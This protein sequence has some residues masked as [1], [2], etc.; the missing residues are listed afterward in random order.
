MNKIFSNKFVKKNRKTSNKKVEGMA[1]FLEFFMSSHVLIYKTS[2]DY[3][4]GI[5]DKKRKYIVYIQWINLW[6]TF[7]R[8][9]FSVL[10]NNETVDSFLA[11]FFVLLNK[12][13]LMV[14]CLILI[15]LM[16]GF[17]GK[18]K[19][20][21]FSKRINLFKTIFENRYTFII[22]SLSSESYIPLSVP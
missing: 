9:Q 11:N 2:Y 21:F 19:K 18:I 14:E 16:S 15:V 3:F 22:H 7:L 1:I 4:D 17:I 8:F 20:P 5:I 10:F 6:I 13:K 12:W